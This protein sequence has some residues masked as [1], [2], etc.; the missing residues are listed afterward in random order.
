MG[1]L[2]AFVLTGQMINF[3]LGAGTS[4]HLLG[5]VLVGVMVGP[6]VGMLVIF[7]VVLVQALLFQDGGIAALGANTFNLAVI[8]AGGGWL[9]YRWAFVLL[10]GGRHRLLAA[11][12]AAYVTTA[13]TGVAAAAELALSGT[14]PLVPALVAVG[15]G[16][17]IVG[18]AET[19][20]TVG[21]LKAVLRSRPGL[22]DE[23]A[24]PSGGARRWVVS[25]TMAAFALT[26]GTYVASTRPDAFEA[27]LES[28]GL[29]TAVQSGAARWDAMARPWLAG[30]VGVALSFALAWLLFRLVA[31]RRST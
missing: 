27:G 30:G 5:G 24:L 11:G 10:G 26:A 16:Y 18:I 3:P 25:L 9:A 28:L 4:A 1:A 21:I 22:V 13:L 20:L 2:A 6:W 12:I 8:G 14:A 19:A 15:G 17:L 23:I 29:S 7:S 31:R